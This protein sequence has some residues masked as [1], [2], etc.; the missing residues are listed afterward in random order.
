MR[1][2]SLLL[3]AT[4]LAAACGGEPG[5]DGKD[6][7]DGADGV[8]GIDGVNGVDG[9]PGPPGPQGPPGDDGEGGGGAGGGETAILRLTGLDEAGVDDDDSVFVEFAGA[10]DEANLAGSSI[11]LAFSRRAAPEFVAS[12]GNVCGG[13]GVCFVE[14]A[15]ARVLDLEGD[16]A[17]DGF[18]QQNASFQLRFDRAMDDRTRDNL[19]D[20]IHDVIGLDD[21]FA[22]TEVVAGLEFN[23]V[24]TLGVELPIAAFDSAG[25]DIGTSLVLPPFTVRDE[26]GD[27]NALTVFTLR[28]GA[29]A[30]DQAEPAAVAFDPNSGNVVAAIRE[31]GKYATGDVFALV[32][33]RAMDI[34][35]TE[36][37]IETRLEEGG[38]F[39]DVD[40]ASVAADTFRVTNLGALVDLTGQAN[41]EELVLEPHDVTSANGITNSTQQLR[42]VITD[43]TVPTLNV[44][45]AG[46]GDTMQV[47]LDVNVPAR[48]RNGAQDN[49]FLVEGD[50]IVW[51]FSEGMQVNTV[52]TN[53]AALLTAVDGDD[54]DNNIAVDANDIVAQAG[55]TRFV[56]TLK[57][58]EA[59]V[60]GNVFALDAM[61][62]ANV[63]DLDNATD[64]G[65]FLAQNQ[66]P[67][68]T[69]NAFIVQAVLNPVVAGAIDTVDV[70]LAGGTD[71]EDNTIEAGDSLVFTFSKKM[72]PATTS[73]E[74]GARIAAG[75]LTGGTR[76]G[77]FVA[78][79]VSDD[80]VVSNEGVLVGNRFT[81]TLQGDQTFT[82]TAATMSF[83][84]I[85]DAVLDDNGLTIAQD[86]DPIVSDAN[87]DPDLPPSLVSVVGVRANAASPCG[88]GLLGEDDTI[89]F[90]FSEPLNA[91]ASVDAAEAAIVAAVNNVNGG[92]D[93]DAGD[94][95]IVGNIVF[96]VVLDAGASVDSDTAITFNLAAA[97]IEDANEV[98]AVALAATM[99]PVDVLAAALAI[100]RNFVENDGR[101][102]GRDSFTV[103]WTCQMD[104][105]A[106]L[107]AIQT[108]VDD[109]MGDG[110]A[111]TT[112]VNNIAYA[113]EILPGRRF[114]VANQA[115]LT[116]EDVATDL[117]I[118]A[119]ND[120][121]DADGEG[122]VDIAGPFALVFDD[123]PIEDVTL[124][125]VAGSAGEQDGVY[126]ADDPL[127]TGTWFLS[128]TQGLT[129]NEIELP[130]VFTDFGVVP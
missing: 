127:V 73:D 58:G 40:V 64:F 51:T 54:T 94:V 88:D 81:Y 18:L 56:Y 84:D 59:V 85:D 123:L 30:G 70:V 13:D 41:V 35:S 109:L 31:D 21:A 37:A 118:G 108:A 38:K 82:I 107:A 63:T 119:E 50:Q 62:S 43:V 5:A 89:T 23:F 34:E 99:A 1:S 92:T 15:G 111:K 86:Q 22:V 90:T 97:G 47:I 72:D 20:W 78:A 95:A 98:D 36:Q 130:V 124:D 32:F 48:L 3:L 75:T 116:I 24:Y 115:T 77:A 11:T 128:S 61:D 121:D 28:D 8:N 117:D 46:N 60:V 105:F 71:R 7:K 68:A 103:T 112:T 33:D 125:F 26:N 79:D 12:V 114:E 104:E 57:V 17:G 42:F 106:T 25:V 96:T 53:L 44:I 19:E 49:N 14:N 39:V 100:N 9:L 16:T 83:G 122:R 10:V 74:L 80:I 4:A 126:T 29:N 87:F 6:G 101:F 27:G 113:I 69:R 120:D 2:F 67:K 45:N 91:G 55:G 102:V 110:T 129:R 52:Q 93:I 65:V 76:A 66:V